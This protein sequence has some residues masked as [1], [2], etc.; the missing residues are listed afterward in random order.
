MK[1]NR[2]V[3]VAA[4]IVLSGLGLGTIAAPQAAATYPGVDV[5]HSAP[6]T[7]S[8]AEQVAIAGQNTGRPDQRTAY[9][10][11]MQKT[12]T[13]KK[14]DESEKKSKDSGKSEKS[15]KSGKSEKSEGSGKSTKSGKTK[16]SEKSDGSPTTTKRKSG[17][18]D[19]KDE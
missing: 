5:G 6:A 8:G 16:K 13:P 2:Q 11:A 10:P 4:T 19:E 14:S 7:P 3:I 18:K 15:G 1:N 9:V 12:A 17:D